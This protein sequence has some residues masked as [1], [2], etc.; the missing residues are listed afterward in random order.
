MTRL[1][2][3][4]KR[5][6]MPP[7]SGDAT[8]FVKPDQKLTPEFLRKQLEHIKDEAGAESIVCLSFSLY[9]E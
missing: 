3:E 2:E 7:W 9:D 8:V 1:T 6:R 4:L 5:V